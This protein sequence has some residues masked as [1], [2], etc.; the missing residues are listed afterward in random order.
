MT[1]Y[2]GGKRGFI[3]RSRPKKYL[4]TDQQKKLKRIVEEC[5][6]HK[7]ITKKELQIAMV[8]CVGPKMRE[9][10]KKPV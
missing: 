2:A 9:T 4:M 1:E 5:G 3:I 6:I 10:R 7:G 8:E